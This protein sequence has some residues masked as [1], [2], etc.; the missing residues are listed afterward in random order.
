MAAVRRHRLKMTRSAAA[1]LFYR[2]KFDAVKT[3]EEF[4]ARLRE[5]VDLPTLTGE[6][7]TV[8]RKTMQPAHASLWLREAP[9]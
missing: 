3:L 5:Y 2:R 7:L 4:N 8:V 6:L 1:R 9:R